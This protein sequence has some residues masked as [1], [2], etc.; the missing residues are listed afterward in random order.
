LDERGRCRAAIA[1]ERRP[2]RALPGHHRW[3][4]ERVVVPHEREA[5]HAALV[6]FRDMA[7]ADRRVLAAELVLFSR[8]PWRREPIGEVLLALGFVPSPEPQSYHETAC[9][10]LRDDDD[11]VFS[12]FATM[13]RR[14]IR[15]A[16]RRP[17]EL[18]PIVEGAHV[19]AME[20]L[21]R[22]TRRRT[23]GEP[24]GRSLAELVEFA[25]TNPALVRITGVFSRHE[26]RLLSF[27]TGLAHG[28]HV[29]YGDAGSTRDPSLRVP[30]GYPALWDL[31]RWAKRI[32]AAWFDLGGIT[33]GTHKS[34]GDPLGGI[35]DFKRMFRGDIVPVADEWLFTPRPLRAALSARLTSLAARLRH[36]SVV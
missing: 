35:S 24:R 12:R 8:D 36:G 18:R 31:M 23:G 21:V 11:T 9:V 13:A 2:T 7:R 25:R 4:A 6:A 3:R 28:D 30:L 10:D 29:S 16:E 19:A 32:G 17:I 26:Q 22:E 1:V 14:N 20:E 5:L 34:V 33:H 15:L 27:A